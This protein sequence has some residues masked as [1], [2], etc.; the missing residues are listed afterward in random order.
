[1]ATVASAMRLHRP[2]RPISGPSTLPIRALKAISCPMVSSRLR[3]RVAPA[4]RITIV[5]AE[6]RIWLPRPTRMLNDCARYWV[7]SALTY[8]F[9]HFRRTGRSLPMPLMVS[10]PPSASIRKDWAS[11]EA[12]NTSRA[13]SLMRGVTS[14]VRTMIGITKPISSRVSF[15]L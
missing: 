13:Y 14:T 3:T 5:V 12:T 4:H 6:F 2:T 11:V 15:T 8:F 1:M 10:M 7:S 9:S